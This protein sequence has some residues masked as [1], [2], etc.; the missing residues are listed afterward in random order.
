MGS[1]GTAG[2][3][4]DPLRPS[5]SS[6]RA[7]ALP[8]GVLP[9]LY[10]GSRLKQGA[11]R[12]SSE[13]G[14]RT[15]PSVSGFLQPSLP[16]Q[17][18]F[19][20]LAPHHRFVDPERLHHLVTLP[21]GDSSV[22]PE[23]HPS[24]RL[25]DL[26]GPARRVSSGSSS[27][28]FASF[29]SLRGRREALPV[30]G[31]LLRSYDLT[32]SLHEDYGTSVRHPPQAWGQD[33]SLPGRLAHPGLFKDRLSSVE[34]Q[35][36]VSLY[37]TWHPGQPH[38]V[39]SGSLS[40]HSVLGHGDPF[41]A[42]YCSSHT[43][44][45]QQSHSTDRGVP[46]NPVSSSVPLASPS[47]PPVFP[48]SSR[49]RRNEQ[50]EASP[51]LPQG[52]VG[53]S[54]RPV[55]GLL[56]S[57]L[58]RGSSLVA[59]S[60]SAEGGRESLPS[61][62]RHQLL[63]GRFRRGLGSPSRRTPRLGSLAPPS[64]GSLYQHER[65]S[66]SSARPAG[67]RTS[68]RGHVGNAVLRQHHH[69]SL[70][71][72]VGRDVFV[73]SELHGQGGSPLGEESSHSSSSPVH[74]GVVQRHRGR[75]K[76]PQS[77]DRVTVDPSPGGS[78][79]AGPQVAS[80]DRSVR[81]LLD[82]EAS[83]LLLS[84]LRS[85]GGRDGCPSPALGRSP[86]IRL[87]S[88][89]HHKE[90]ASQT[91]VIEELRVDSHSS[92]LASEGLVS[93]PSGTIIRRFHHTVRSKRSSKTA[94]LPPVPPKSAYASADCMATLKRFA[95]QAGFSPAVA[96]QLIFSRRLSTRLNYQA[97]WG[98]YRKWCKDFHHRSSS[99]SIAKIADF[100]TYM[101]KNKGAALSTIKGY[102]AMLAAVFKFP[103]PEISSSP[104]LKDLVRSFEISAPRP[105]FPPPPWDLDKVLEFL[106]GPPFE[107]LARASFLD[108]TKKALFLL[109]MA[110]AKRVSE[111]Q[112]LSFS[113]SFQ[114]EDLVLH[115]DPFFRAKTE[116]VINP[117]PRSVIVPSLLDFAG[118][119][120]E[121]LHC[122]VRA[123]KYHR[124]AAGSTSFIPP[125]LFVS[126]KN[127]K[128]SMSKNAMS[129]YLRQLIIDSGAVSSAR[130]PRAHDIRGIAKS[131][132]YYSN[133]SLTSLIQV[134]TWKSKRVFA[135]R[136]LKEVSAT[137]DNIQQFGPLVIAGD[138]LKP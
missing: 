133:L 123:V 115:Y 54:G 101:F 137:Q 136:Y 113:V 100:L 131:L 68:D 9:T 96:G 35:A 49:L 102:R 85:T 93:R 14:S 57:S 119:L 118:D 114:G 45:S 90:S 28:R 132:N 36:P 38:E 48:D 78:R 26:P 70:S 27:S 58:S 60:G 126:P 37:R 92:V 125:R 107:P 112:A 51:T 120:P 3:L 15:S 24:R 83:S 84:S 31:P 41:Y 43:S 127:P 50:N 72:S 124:K 91:E 121:R 79:S 53:L 32:S 34:G 7:S 33:A 97:R 6:I 8:A 117:L 99:P 21:H 40:V 12:P 82:S 4:S 46:I 42:L 111:L 22:S 116:S 19:G 95:I 10:Q 47:R 59:E 20:V 76:S 55:P 122:P 77:G 64:E 13:G 63:L 11:S 106:S 65:A 110:T 88:D 17:E 138:R 128:R 56:V 66:S 109:A 86:S 134:A 103:L 75:L 39:V 105:I 52:P 104:V 1:G 129:F 30:Q 130:P 69:S 5:T 2:R 16:R 23:F 67:L 81:N 71:S 74:H 98:T 61:S 135:S 94:P 44:T 18:G 89:R 80:D 87:S 73:R 108:K 29:S 25:D 62:S